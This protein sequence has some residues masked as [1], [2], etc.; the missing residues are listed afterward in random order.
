MTM[1]AQKLIEL[2][3]K[4]AQRGSGNP[5]TDL[6]T[7]NV[8]LSTWIRRHDDEGG[9]AELEIDVVKWDN[10]TQTVILD[11]DYYLV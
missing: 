11:L 2:I 4:K 9:N 8:V 7:V 10:E 1:T 5:D 6:A 3:T